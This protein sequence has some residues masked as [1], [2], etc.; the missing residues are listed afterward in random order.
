M[1]SVCFLSVLFSGYTIYGCVGA[2]AE[3]LTLE[4][5]ELGV[6]V[7][8]DFV[9][10]PVGEETSV[11]MEPL[12]TEAGLEVVTETRVL[13]NPVGLLLTCRAELEGTTFEE[14]GL[15]G[16]CG[17]E[18]GGGGEGGVFE[19]GGGGAACDLDGVLPPPPLLPPLPPP[20]AAT[21]PTS[22]KR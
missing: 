22:S 7:E 5:E 2:V 16:N 8:R 21:K 4:V 14:E 15:G 3:G 17:V 9:R 18:D 13:D 11:L 6:L 19:G 1:A 12:E 10:L 20:F